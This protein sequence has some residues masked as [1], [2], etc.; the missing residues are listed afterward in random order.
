MSNREAEIIKYLIDKQE[1]RIPIRFLKTKGILELEKKL[2]S[3]RPLYISGQFMKMLSQVDDYFNI[4]EIDYLCQAV[5]KLEKDSIEKGFNS[6]FGQD[7]HKIIDFLAQDN[8]SN[9]TDFLEMAG[10]YSFF[11][12]VAEEWSHNI[13][14]IPELIRVA[15]IMWLF[16]NS[17]EILLHQVDRKILH[18]L[19]TNKNLK[20]TSNINFFMKNVS[21]K[22]FKDHA[23]A[24]KINKVLCDLLKIKEDNSSIFGKTSKPKAIRNKVSH[25]NMYYDKESKKVVL[26]SGEEYDSNDFTSQYFEMFKFMATWLKKYANPFNKEDM[27]KELRM[28]LNA[29]SKQYLFIERSYKKPFG[30][31]IINIQ[32][33]IASKKEANKS[34]K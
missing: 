1:L 5:L 6:S 8:K 10:P 27:R 9:M 17:Y 18:N 22:E 4:E 16:V 7:N 3:G 26:L 34:V 25:S 12:E 31:F 32:R 19:N 30:E 24:E 20:M 15:L 29:L 2:A 33:E 11:L 23:T 28:V 21:R 13:E 14:K